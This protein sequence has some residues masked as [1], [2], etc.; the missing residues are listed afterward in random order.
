MNKIVEF[1]SSMFSPEIVTIIVAAL[2]IAELRGALPLALGMYKFSLKKALI[3]SFLGNIIPVIPVLIFLNFFSHLLMRYD[4][5][6]KFF[7]WW[8]ART[9]KHSEIIE[10][11]EAIGLAIFVG[12]P[13]PMTGAWSG[14]VAAYLLG[15]K[16]RYA[17]PAIVLGVFLAGVIVASTILG[18][19]KIL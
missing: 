8:F 15:I 12:I 7:T 13:L 16:F 6:K 14:C 11:Y 9:R 5:A 10:K 19:I 1:L 2:P 18:L 4:W 3:L 17:F